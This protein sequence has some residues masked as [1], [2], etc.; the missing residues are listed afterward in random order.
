M[1]VLQEILKWSMDRPEWQRDALRRL[2]SNSELEDE[3]IAAL[4]EICKSTHGLADKQEHT[5]LGK[6]HLPTDSVEVGQVNI[7][8]IYHQCGVNALADD[9]EV[10]FGPGLTVV[11]GDNAAGKSGYTRI[12]KS[13]CRARGSEDILGNVL[14]GATPLKP[15]VSIKYTV[16]DDGSQ[17]EWTYEDDDESIARV[18]VFDSHSAAVY[19]TQKTDVAFR[20]FGL[21]MFDKL[22]KACKLIRANLDREKKFLDSSTLEVLELQED[23]TAAKFVASLTSL[24]DP[25]KVKALGTL[26]DAENA[27][28]TLL[29]K[30]LVD[31]QA[32]DPGKKA[33]ELALRARRFRTLIK[34]LKMIDVALSQ[35]TI[36]NVLDAQ[37]D[38]RAKRENAKK[39]REDT[40]PVDLLSKTGSES[41][42]EMWEAARKFSEDDAYPDQHFPVTDD[43]A[44]C[45]LCQQAIEESAATRLK[46]FEAFVVSVSEKEF[47][48]AREDFGQLYKELEK[49]KP[50]DETTEEIIKEI[51]M[52]T[53]PL[54]DKVEV[55]IAVG[56]SLRTAILNGLK[57]KEGRP[58]DLPNYISV[59][60]KVEALVQQMDERVKSL[61]EKTDVDKKEKITSEFHELKARQTLGK[62]QKSI[63]GEIERKKKVAAYGLC[64]D[65][66]K[67]NSITTKS[68]AITKIAVTQQLK[69]SFQKE[70]TSLNFKHVEVELKEVGGDLGSLY[71]KLVLT[72]APGVELPKVVSEGEARCLS[73]AA[74]FAELST[75]EDLSAILFDDPVSSLDYKWRGS[76]ARRLVEKAKKRQVI[77]FTHD[78]VFLL[79]LRQYA[80]EHGVAR[81]DQ[82]VKQ[83]NT[84]A[85]VC[86]NELPWVA[87]PVGKRIGFLKKSWQAADKLFRDGH[88]TLYEKEAI[89]IYGLLRESWERGLEEVLLGRVVERYR[90][91]VQ[92]QQ[93]EKIADITPE[94]C[95]AVDIGM[96]KCS[97]WLPGHDQAPAAKEDVPEPDEL[98]VDIE[99]L[100]SWVKAIRKRRL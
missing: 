36:N 91:G 73:I 47:R 71:H 86:D 61:Q 77:V 85:G 31:L 34:H 99:A 53:E 45:V 62:H 16:G 96:T 43:D 52:E 38:V 35:E 59:A 69:K 23:T 29:E 13:A 3:D 97:K 65:D 15:S 72:R 63:L 11:Y 98:K 56:E 26:S 22:A 49:L 74:F 95:K 89:H 4:T 54:A 41:W 80:D 60:D 9:Q 79:I 83:L 5:P 30:Q 64:L 1:D 51:R 76:V 58:S 14:S 20:P 7:Q 39:L 88:Q 94:D 18:S 40:F 78:I 25:E 67:T 68:T 6:E 27:R 55:S 92:T 28:L 2:V 93:I 10:S 84:G 12:L 17:Q 32:K 46:K 24:T 33:G 57:L 66:L 21:D 82:H 37:K 19:L 48:A 75:T 70:L 100:E 50:A 44:R 8:S 81:L 42:G 87:S 90:T